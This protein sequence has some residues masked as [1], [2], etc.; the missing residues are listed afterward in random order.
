MALSHASQALDCRQDYTNAL[1][2][3][4]ECYMELLEFNDAAQAY[5]ALSALE[6]HNPA[7]A[8]CESKA[9][10]LSDASP[11]EVLALHRGCTMGDVKKAYHSQC[12]Q[13]HPDKHH[14]SDEATRR[15]NTMFK[16]ITS[17][18]EI[19]SDERRR[20]ELDMRERMREI[21][22]RAQEAPPHEVRRRAH[23][24]PSDHRGFGVAGDGDGCSNQGSFHE[25]V[26]GIFSDDLR[27]GDIDLP[28]GDLFRRRGA[29]DPRDPYRSGPGIDAPSPFHQR[30][31]PGRDARFDAFD[32]ADPAE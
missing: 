2:L 11:Y 10:A 29:Y 5:S 7:W 9:T 6:P 32:S 8:D 26:R 23:E 24:M 1:M 27:D 13:W 28:D 4:A 22:R 18:Y 15:A 12:L 17:A 21:R 14:G 3:Q 16:R 20:G 31:A 30:W 25:A 19:L